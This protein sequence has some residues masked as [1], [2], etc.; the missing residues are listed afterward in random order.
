[1]LKFRLEL[2]KY[3]DEARFKDLQEIVKAWHDLQK[4]A[5]EVLARNNSEEFDFGGGDRKR[6][7]NNGAETVDELWREHG[8][9]SSE[10]NKTLSNRNRFYSSL[11][12]AL[13]NPKI[14]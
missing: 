14:E 10:K 3:W 6:L 11:K 1:M 13:C 8:I 5:F 9:N 12:I 7:K 4:G 2:S